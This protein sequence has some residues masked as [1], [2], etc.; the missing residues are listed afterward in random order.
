LP[1]LR[2]ADALGPTI[3]EHRLPAVIG[4]NEAMYV[5]GLDIDAQSLAA[6]EPPDKPWAARAP[7]FWR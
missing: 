5:H 7:Q 1:Q 2:A 4:D 6:G 3:P